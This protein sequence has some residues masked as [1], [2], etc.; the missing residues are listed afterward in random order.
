MTTDLQP[1]DKKTSRRARFFLKVEVDG[2]YRKSVSGAFVSL[3]GRLL[4]LFLLLGSHAILGRLVPPDQYGVFAMGLT[5]LGFLLIFKDFGLQSAGVQKAD[6]SEMDANFIFWANLAFAAVLSGLGVVVAPFLASFYGS[7]AVEPVLMVMS[8]AA[9][10]GSLS[11]AHIMLLRRQMKFGT[12]T[13]IELSA[14]AGAIAAALVVAF[15]TRDVWALLTLYL[16]QQV[17]ITLGAY[18]ATGWLPGRPEWSASH[19]SLLKFGGGVALANTVYYLTN[20]INAVLIG[21]FSGAAALG[22]FNRAQQLFQIPSNVMFNSIYTVVYA[23]LSR[24][25]DRPAEYDE[26]YRACL[27][28]V[29][30]MY[31]YTGAVILVFAPEVVDVILGPGWDLA[32]RLLQALSFALVGSGMSQMTGILLQS[33]GRIKEFQLW[34]FID[35]GIRIGAILIG[36]Q[37]GIFGLTIGFAVATTLVTAPASLWYVG[38]RGPVSLSGQVQTIL[39]NAA[40]FV[41]TLIAALSAK[42]WLPKLDIAL[43]DLVAC[44]TCATVCALALALALPVT[45]S[46]VVLLVKQI[47]NIMNGITRR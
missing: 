29:G 26:F 39:P 43:V 1:T 17:G 15:Y 13:V 2:L 47:R 30:M 36:A 8:L 3:S 7:S 9:F 27:A 23:S 5:A 10:L 45:R 6:L 22:H 42:A 32:G 16:V 46:S 18:I 38:R 25:K 14:L 44:V 31:M 19:L 4:N 21:Y 33:Q 28:K 40:F 41:I 24:L 34:G 37:W 35:S 20:N 11:A 12:I